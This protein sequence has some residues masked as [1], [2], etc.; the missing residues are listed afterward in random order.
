MASTEG[1]DHQFLSYCGSQQVTSLLLFPIHR[2]AGG[3]LTDGSLSTGS[4][5]HTRRHP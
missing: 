2:T 5:A 4:E 3:N 1:P